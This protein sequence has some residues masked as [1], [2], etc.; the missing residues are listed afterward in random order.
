MKTP[1]KKKEGNNEQEYYFPLRDRIQYNIQN[2]NLLR[3]LK[4][5]KE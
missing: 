3:H 4:T 1:K 2:I 5:I